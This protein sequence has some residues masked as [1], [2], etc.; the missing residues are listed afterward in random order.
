MSTRIMTVCWDLQMSPVQKAVLISLADQANDDGVCWP[1]ADTICTRT[2]LSERAVRNALRWLEKAGALETSVRQG[3]STV[4]RITA[5]KFDAEYEDTPAPRAPRHQ[6]PQ[7]PDASHPGMSCP[8]PRHQ[9]PDTPAP[10]APRTV[11]E[12]SREPSKNRNATSSAFGI[13]QMIANNPHG[14]SE[15]VLRDFLINR[16]RLKAALTET[17]WNRLNAELDRVVEAGYSAEEAM[18]EVVTAGWRGVKLD[19]LRNRLQP[20]RGEALIPV[21][22]IV[23]AYHTQC[24]KLAPVTVVD[25]KIMALLSERWQEHEA[26]QDLSFWSDYFAIASRIHSVFYRGQSRAPYFEALISRDVFRDVM[27]GRANA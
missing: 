5:D 18:V 4:Y 24:P 20:S 3:R 11:I 17:A 10:R 6:M 16:K 14:L 13:D 21:D 19:W 25:Q 15:S 2:C 22:L 8:P 9:M 1:S 27:E 12:P 7:A 26:H 23:E